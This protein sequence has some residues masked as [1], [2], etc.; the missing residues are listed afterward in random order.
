MKNLQSKLVAV[1]TNLKAPK[2]Q[3]NN[4]GNY[5]YRS[6]E[7]ILESVKPLLK[8]EGLL[9][10]ISDFVNHDPLYIVATATVSDG[11][12]S[13]NVTAQA[14]IELGKKGMAVAQCFGASS[15]YARKYALNGLFLIDDTRDDDE[16]NKHED[17]TENDSKTN[18]AWTKTTTQTIEA[19]KEW[20]PELGPQFDMAKKAIAEKGYTLSDI[21]TKWKVSKKC[22]KLLTS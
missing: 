16:T 1:Q 22:E 14:G 9:L 21:R 12:D 11:T 19:Q 17:D 5:N 6:C 2:N 15:S 18:S 4:Y 7:D 8:K 10:T 20:L 3:R 13:L